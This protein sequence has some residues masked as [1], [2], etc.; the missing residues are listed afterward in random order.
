MMPSSGSFGTNSSKSYYKSH[1]G[2][3]LNIIFNKIYM[4][5]V[6]N[7]TVA[8]PCVNNSC[9]RLIYTCSRM[10][11]KL[12]WMKKKDPF[13]FIHFNLKFIHRQET[14][15]SRSIMLQLYL[16]KILM[17][18]VYFVELSTAEMPEMEFETEEEAKQSFES[19]VWVQI[20]IIYEKFFNP[21]AK[22]KMLSTQFRRLSC[23]MTV[24]YSR[25][26]IHS[27]IWLDYTQNKKR[28]I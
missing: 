1:Y 2:H 13:F 7:S 24:G 27:Q 15:H 26:S 23:H 20:F 4:K 3:F 11:F 8:P 14:G 22:I 21:L 28:V 10:N 9:L 6:V 16:K 19:K 12:K 25:P 17:P 18:C 5:P